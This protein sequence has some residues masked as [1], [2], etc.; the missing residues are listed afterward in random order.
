MNSIIITTI[1]TETEDITKFKNLDSW[2]LI[3]VGDKK[4]PEYNDPKIDFISAKYRES[5]MDLC[6][7]LNSY[8][9]KNLG[10]LKAIENASNIIYETDDD[11]IPYDNFPIDIQFQCQDFLQSNNKF[12]NVY[13]F[14]SGEKIWNRGFPLEY[15]TQTNKAEI[16]SLG[17]TEGFF[18]VGVYQTLIDHDPDVDAIYRL[19]NG[20]NV[21]FDV[22]S[23]FVIINGSYAPFNSQSTFWRKECFL[24]MYFP[25]HVSWRFADILRGYI[26]QRLMHHDGF[27]LGFYKSLVFQDRFR[28]DYMKD[29]VDEIPMYTN[30]VKT[31]EILDGLSLT[32]N[33]ITNMSRV[34]DALAKNGIIDYKELS[35]LEVWF[36]S[37]EEAS[38]KCHY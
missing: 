4:T 19:T 13:G 15:I 23:P 33:K 21:N 30:V 12:E 28:T 31:I 22:P 32:D 2:N 5:L 29:F 38:K 11:N 10:Y 37:F 34:Y 3:L 14:L 24:Y 1:N 8:C 17:P 16:N 20:K 36:K 26:A 27:N 6:I 9:R 25:V 7:P 35:V 18:N